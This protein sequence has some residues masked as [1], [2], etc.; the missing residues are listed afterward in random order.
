MS[1]AAL[2]LLFVAIGLGLYLWLVEMPAEKKQVEAETAAKKLVDFKED[3]VQ[4]FTIISSRGE[5]EV[6]RED[7]RWTI[8]KPKP[9]E[10]DATA[11]GEFLRTLVLA[12]VSRVVDETGT[13]LKA[14][15][16]ETPSLTVSLRLASGTQ[17]VRVG[18]AGPLSA[19]LYAKRDD[20]PKVL[21]TTLAGRDLLTKSIQ[22]FRRKRVLPF[23]RAQVTRLKIA[24]PRETVVLYREGHGD[25]AVW[26]IKAPVETAAD[27]AE[28]SSLLFALEDL[29][30]QGFIDDPKEH[31]AKRAA[32]G[33]SLATITLHEGETDRTVSLF[34]DP[35]DNTAAYAESTAREPLYQIARAA[36]KD[37]A[38]GLFD[39]RAKQL[40]AAEPD[41]VKTLVI[42]TGGQEY[43]L[44]RE[45]G[46]WIVDGDPNAKADA[47]RINMFVTRVVRLQAEKIVTETPTD[48]KRYGLASPPAE[49]IAAGEQGKLLGRIAFGREEQGLAYA[50]GSAMT[51][52]FQVRPDILKEIPKKDDLLGR[53]K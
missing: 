12:Q 38:R 40:I 10:A 21:L 14:Y 23:N 7:G 53:S 6:A 25:K 33:K 30:A 31:A 35:R 27:Q 42:K 43:A 11:V 28:V 50:L 20:S 32:L 2:V 5:M 47:A 34:L 1:R 19:T 52:I 24:G 29:K 22:E 15:G 18:D 44:S 39:L 16:L 45:G 48:L 26:K 3:D 36:A 9:M 4:G 49:L 51:G 13:G 37:L 46:A 8:R 17:T 41:Q